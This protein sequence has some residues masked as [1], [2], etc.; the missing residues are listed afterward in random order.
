MV[1]QLIIKDQAIR[2][3]PGGLLFRSALR[4]SSARWRREIQVASGGLSALAII[5]IGK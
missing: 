4:V 5:A 1:S 3:Q 2:V